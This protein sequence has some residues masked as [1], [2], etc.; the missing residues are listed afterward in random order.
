MYPNPNGNK[1]AILG[2]EYPPK[3]QSFLYPPLLPLETALAAAGVE[4]QEFQALS[5]EV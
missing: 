3:P 1:V 2:L 4:W 5:E